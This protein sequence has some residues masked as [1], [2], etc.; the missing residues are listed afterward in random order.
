MKSYKYKCAQ[1]GTERNVISDFPN[2]LVYCVQ[3]SKNGKIPALMQQVKEN[4]V[5]VQL[6][7]EDDC[8]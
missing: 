4:K 7:I 3:C 6:L 5:N 8:K 2:E 1:C